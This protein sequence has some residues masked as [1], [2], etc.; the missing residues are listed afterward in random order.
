MFVPEFP[1]PCDTRLIIKPQV[2]HV[3]DWF[4]GAEFKQFARA[5]RELFGVAVDGPLDHM[6]QSLK[7]GPPMLHAYIPVL[8]LKYGKVNGTNFSIAASCFSRMTELVDQGVDE[9]VIRLVT[10][11]T[12]MGETICR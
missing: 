3:P 7:V 2:R 9:N 4:P 11:T 10:A 12:Y 6:K 5:G 8:G 1:N